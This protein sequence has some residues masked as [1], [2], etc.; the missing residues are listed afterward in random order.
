MVF[1]N[2]LP[3]WHSAAVSVWYNTQDFL[4]PS[5]PANMSSV[6]H[7]TEVFYWAAAD[8]A[9]VLNKGAPGF[10]GFAVWQKGWVV[11]WANC[12][13]VWHEHPISFWNPFWLSGL[14]HS[15]EDKCPSMISVPF[16]FI[17][18]I[19]SWT[20]KCASI[21]YMILPLRVRALKGWEHPY[22]L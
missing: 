1:L 22:T 10:E 11:P 5:S 2:C 4:F 20:G 13:S 16:V 7:F 6:S 8:A 19:K 18:N 12:R 15:W 14:C 3:S 9:G 17:L 21:L